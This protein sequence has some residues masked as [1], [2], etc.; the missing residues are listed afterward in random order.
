MS[1]SRTQKTLLNA[2]VNFIFYFLTMIIGFVSRKIF[3]GNLG[4]DFIGLTGTLNSILG[5]LNLAELGIGTSIAVILYKPIF[6]KDQQQINEVIS[7]FGFIYNVIGKIILAIAVVISLFLPFIFDK[8][9][10]PMGIVYFAFYSFLTSSL[11]SYFINYKQILLSADQRNYVITAYYQTSVMV[12]NILQL[13][14]C[15]YTHNYYV[16]IAVELTFSIFYS[17]MLN[18]RIRQV[19]PWLES[20]IKL[21]RKLFKKY[22][23]I[24]TK[25]KQ[26]FVQRVAF[27]VLNETTTPLIYAYSTLQAVALYGNYMMLIDKGASLVTMTMGGVNAGIGNLIAEG[28]KKRI[29]SVFWELRA[30]RYWAAFLVVFTFYYFIEPF[31]RLWLGAEY[32][33]DRYLLII[34]LLNVFIKQT[35]TVVMGF[36]NG[37]GLFK[38]VWSPVVEAILNISSAIILGQ[39]F[40][41][42]GVLLGTTISLSL[43]ICL[44]K[45]Y[46]L[47]K[48]G[49][50]M[51]VFSYWFNTGKFFLLSA[52]VWAIFHMLIQQY[53]DF[54]H[55]DSF[56]ELILY[57]IAIVPLYA[58]ITWIAYYYFS[59]GMKD[60]TLRLSNL[61]TI[62]NKFVSKK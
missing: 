4:D 37:Y 33:F 30:F 42:A 62:K 6:N 18:V 27:T 59:S 58:L 52:G 29:L 43:I 36:L 55:I 26:V 8:T 12:K 39:Y 54:D 46:F 23:E 21:G 53:V 3:L 22:P 32:I 16:W 49:F 13:A 24:V 19:Y 1:E 15:Y 41:M 11:L 60:F 10:L 25:T 20:D 9:T 5:F 7:V 40:G 28:N 35:R 45:P 61:I 50:H 48:E 38:D 34:I 57:G 51:P 44:W 31:I 47:Y 17:I 56:F 2:R 14:L